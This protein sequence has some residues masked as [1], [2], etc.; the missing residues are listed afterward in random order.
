MKIF[1]SRRKRM[2]RIS[3]SLEGL[4]RTGPF[5]IQFHDF[6]R[7]PRSRDNRLPAGIKFPSGS[8]AAR[9]LIEYFACMCVRPRA[10]FCPSEPIRHAYVFI[11]VYTYLY[12]C[13]RIFN[14]FKYYYFGG[15][16]FMANNCAL[17]SADVC[18]TLSL[19]IA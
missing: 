3:R 18:G 5:K 9:V 6:S 2:R 7:S 10:M 11:Y 1:D 19:Q 15:R 16:S 14:R 12:I 4:L 17:L 8:I 13:A